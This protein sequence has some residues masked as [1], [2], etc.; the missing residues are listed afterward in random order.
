MGDLLRVDS[1]EALRE[2]V[3]GWRRAGESVGLVPTMGALHDGH[4]SLVRRSNALAR[5]TVVSIFV[6]PTQFGPGEDLE[7][8]PRTV[9][10]DCERLR[11]VATGAR[12]CDLVFLPSASAIYPPDGDPASVRTWVDVEGV[13]AGL[14]GDQRPGH[15]RGV[16]TVVAKLL[17]LVQPDVAV[18]GQKD[19][20]QLAVIR[21]MVRDLHLPV[22]IVGA[23]IVRE[24][25]GLALSSRNRYLD[26]AQ[27][28]AATV[29]ARSLRVAR[30]ALDAGDR[31][32]DALVRRVRAVL[33][34]EPAGT[35][36]YVG[37]VDADTF[38][39]VA[40]VTGATVIAVAFRLGTTRLLDNLLFDPDAEIDPNPGL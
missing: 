29:L 17:N 27:R 22:E 7:R 34:A 30:A 36:D 33:D 20:Q 35:T 40:E 6:N 31:D 21:R 19:A 11:G 9:G 2:K 37:V 25:D 12:G 5:R 23:P 39:P 16:A 4:L 24:S 32:A 14:E 28:R 10:S 18:F 8:Y 1:P 15:F 38:E 26:S 3:R 13:S